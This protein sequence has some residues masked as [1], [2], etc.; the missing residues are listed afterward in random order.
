[1][2][3]R[4][5]SKC[6]PSVCQAFGRRN[7]RQEFSRTCNPVLLYQR[8]KIM[9]VK[10]I[11]AITMLCRLRSSRAVQMCMKSTTSMCSQIWRAP[12]ACAKIREI[13]C[14]AH[15]LAKRC[16]TKSRPHAE[17]HT[18]YKR[19]ESGSTEQLIFS[20]KHL[21]VHIQNL[22]LS[23]FFLPIMF[24]NSLSISLYLTHKVRRGL[25]D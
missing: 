22:Q 25:N 6:R 9:N 20:K 12:I 14:S 3:L 24:Q 11:L 10:N 2:N 13:N 23:P 8:E 21:L 4:Y 16:S 15:M 18:P 17:K 1:M 7:R 19:F 5:R